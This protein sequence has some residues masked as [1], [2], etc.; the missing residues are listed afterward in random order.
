MILQLLNPDNYHFTVHALPMLIVGVAI[1]ILGFFVIIRERMSP[2]GASFL[3]M[4]LSVSLYLIPAALNSASQDISL[5]LV[6]IK[7]ENLGAIFIPSSLLVLTTALFGLTHRYRSVIAASIVLSILFAFGLFFT[8][9]HVRRVQHFSWGNYGRYGP[10]G[11][12]FICYFFAIMVFILRLYWQEYRR[13]TTERQMKRYRGL[14]TAISGGFL[15]SVDFLAAI[16][17]PVYPFGYVF[18][19]FV[20]AVCTYVILRYRLVD[21]TPELAA[22]QILETMQ[23][24]VIVTSTD[25]RIRVINDV[26]LKMLGYPRS[27]LIGRDLRSVLP[28]PPDFSASVQAGESAASREMVWQGR[29]SKYEVNMSVSLLSDPQDGEPAGIVYVASDITER[30]HAEKKLRESEEKYRLIFH[31]SPIGIFNYD[32]QLHIT[33]CN[34]S[35]IDI[36]RSS[37]KNLIGLDMNILSDQRVLPAIREAIEGKEGIYEGYY[38]ATTSLA[39]I[40]IAMHTAPIVGQDGKIKGGVGLVEDITEQARMKESLQEQKWFAENLIENSAVATFVLDAQHK[41]VLWNKACEELTGLSSAAMIGTDNQWKP[42]Y[43]NKRPTIADVVIGGD[44]DE[45]PAL[46]SNHA[47]STLSPD[48]LHAEGW[49]S[50]LHGKDRY[51]LFDAAPLYDSNGVLIAAIQTLQD[52]TERKHAEEEINRNYDTQ[53]VI[54]SLLRLSLEKVPLEDIL[55]RALDLVLSIPWL[56][57]QSRGAIFLSENEHGLLTLKAQRNL[58]E[59]IQKMCAGVPTGKCICGQAALTQKIMFVDSVDER[60]EISY[61]GIYPH[62]HYCVPIIFAERTLGVVNVYVKSGH[63]SNERE[64]E[65]LVT[66]A[67]TLAGIIVRRQAED[68]LVESEQKLQA[69]TDTAADAIILIDHEEKIIYWNSSA[70]SM[71]GYSPE[72]IMGKN[73]MVIIPLRYRKTHAL[74]FKIF[75][76]TGQGALLGKT[77]QVFAVKKDGTEIPIELAVS[78]I[79]LKGQWHAAGIIRDIS[80]RKKLESQLMQAQKMEAVGQL[81]GGIAHDFNNILSA[82]VGY[83]N[84][85]QM[86]MRTDDPLRE[87]LSQI[88]ASAERAASLTQ[89]LLAFSRKQ[90]ISPKNIDLNES[91]R[92]VEMFLIRT[93]GEDIVL[94]T[95]LSEEALTIFF[96]PTQIEQVL[97]NLATNARDAMPK[98]GKLIIETRRVMLDDEY[99]RSHGFG[100]PG[101]YAL[102]TVSDTGEGM[103]EQTQK[104]IFEPFFTTKELGRGTG[105]GLA[106]VYGIVKQNNGYI[107]V[108]SEVGSGT[109]FKLYLPFVNA[110]SEKEQHPEVQQPLRGG[111]ETILFAEDNETVRQLNRDLLKEFGYTV[112]EAT[113]GEEALQ[114]FREHRDRISLIILDVI[115]PKKNGREV[116]EE[117]S[118]SKSN[119]KVIFTSG[120][121]ADLIQKENVLEKGL[122]FLSKPFSPQALLRTVRGVLDQ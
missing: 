101:Y 115:M 68:S 117:V 15:G 91:I 65:L 54:N 46:Y 10:F 17:I 34:D 93:I 42:F 59:R 48:A 69:I 16:G 70:S 55:N 33:D 96:D 86:K 71:L 100:L 11:Y 37:R 120:Y 119:V 73:I 23:G 66:I 121:P 25:G 92:K 44:F 26:A 14:L 89:S 87:Y 35:F 118:R 21:I 28:V 53:A 98:G 83:G 107:N 84:I 94:S 114:K 60:H 36:L 27:E 97:M 2:V 79:P 50:N 45:L 22:G 81:S 7:I 13:C 3:F 76:E 47:K 74:A 40:H 1:L 29:N 109:T 110:Q 95:S 31:N 8:D 106:I 9:L 62:G 5:S 102:L 64:Q 67:N 30:K 39:E 18:V 38:Q 6:W 72:E 20:V 78:G 75:T 105:L 12:A 112:I 85:L 56:V 58:D 103:D 19:G 63:K 113:D 51:I 24:A 41:I 99:I 57:S 4:C 108:Y 116:Y 111:T 82:I 52:I 32:T 104:K 77:Y 80:E 61:D 90:V 88:L 122:H 43:E 49:R